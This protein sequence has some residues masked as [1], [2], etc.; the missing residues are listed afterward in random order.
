MAN[1]RRSATEGGIGDASPRAGIVRAAARLFREKGFD[2]TTVRDIAAAVGMQS[3]SPFYYFES[4]HDILLAVM[5]QGLRDALE[6]T[7]AALDPGQS[8]PER[9]RALV[10]THFR[11]L[12][13][14]G[15]EFITVMLYDWR[16]LPAEHRRKLAPLKDRYDAIW[17]QTLEDLHLLARIEVDPKLAR[18]MILGAIN[19]TAT[20]Y[21]PDATGHG[22]I[23]LDRIAD[24]TA[25]FF[26]RE[27]SGEPHPAQAALH[28]VRHGLEQV[29]DELAAPPDPLWQS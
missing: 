10:R 18:L 15:S 23:D 24:E 19:F 20:W 5:E 6:R 17:Q 3:G 7:E 13:D 4:K 16:S 29:R 12:H 22:A 26:L 1:P 11:V 21:R 9:F 14:A 2:G 28:D 27:P 25:R 8:A